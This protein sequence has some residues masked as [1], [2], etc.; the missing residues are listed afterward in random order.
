LF[1]RSKHLVAELAA[2]GEVL[3]EGIAPFGELVVALPVEGGALAADGQASNG[4]AADSGDTTPPSVLI[5]LSGLDP[6]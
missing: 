1:L 4:H 6:S 5:T 2:R 3:D